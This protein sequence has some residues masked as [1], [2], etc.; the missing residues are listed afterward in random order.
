MRALDHP[1]TVDDLYAMPDDGSKH[2]LA[3]GLLLSEPLPGFRHG[4]VAA[5]VTGL[6]EAFVR[7]RGRGLGTVLT[8]DAGFVLARDPDT[9]RGPDVAFVSRERAE[10]VSDPARA[11]E[12]PPELAV[13]V[14][15]PSNSAEAIHAKV[16]DY[17][18][19]GTR[20]VWVVDPERETVAAYRTLLSPRA[21]FRDD[22]L[23]GE[24][25][26]PGFRVKV[27]ALFET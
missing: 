10:A 19:A 27:A 2:E 20:L 8:G 16:A 24:D 12:G 22:E 14:L 18:A 3:A 1:F 4:R 26:L 7:D 5:R 25:V 11:F 15:S 13:E 21:L 9:V 23:D 17:L 6:L